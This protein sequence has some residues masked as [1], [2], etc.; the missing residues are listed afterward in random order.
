MTESAVG[1]GQSYG[2]RAVAALYERRSSVVMQATVTDRRYN[3][4]IYEMACS[5]KRRW[6]IS[7]RTVNDQC[8]EAGFSA[9]PVSG[10]P[11]EKERMANTSTAGV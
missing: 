11:K 9:S 1:K 4:S 8:A 5:Q 2:R 3:K 6:V 10:P 7:R